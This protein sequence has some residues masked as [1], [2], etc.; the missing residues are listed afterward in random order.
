AL[1]GGR[2]RARTCD[3]VARAGRGAP[4]HRGSRDFEMDTVNLRNARVL[5]TGGAGLI[6]SHI[7]DRLL[8]EPAGEG[9][10]LDNF[11]RARRENLSAALPSNRVTIVEGDIRNRSL[12]AEWMKGV[13]VVF[14]QAAIRITQCA[15]EPGLAVDV[16]INGTQ[17]VLD[18]A[19]AAGV[20]KVVAPP[21]APAY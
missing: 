5:V 2:G 7:V 6:G 11:S 16:L 14:H 9:I 18:A 3:S 12:V 19:V 21:S 1:L 17:S 10:V 4:D 15:E 8:L 13:D 20:R